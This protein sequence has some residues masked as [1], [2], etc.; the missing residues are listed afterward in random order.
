MIVMIT[1]LG[2]RSGASWAVLGTQV[3]AFWGVLKASLEASWSNFDAE[4]ELS[5]HQHLIKLGFFVEISRRVKT[6]VFPVTE[7]LACAG[8]SEF[9]QTPEDVF[10]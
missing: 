10:I 4:K 9:Y 3:G 6:N 8:R 2:R 7:L 1:H 5:W